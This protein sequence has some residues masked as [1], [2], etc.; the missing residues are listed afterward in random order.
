MICFTFF[1][2]T[3][4]NWLKLRQEHP[5]FQSNLTWS[6]APM[7]FSKAGLRSSRSK[8]RNQVSPLLN[9]LAGLDDLEVKQIQEEIQFGQILLSK[10]VKDADVIDMTERIK[11]LKQDKI[12]Q[13]ALL[14]DFNTKQ[15]QAVSQLVRS[16]CHLQHQ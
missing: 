15:G 2:R 10:G 8:S 9:C 13:D 16:N 14:I 7:I 12:I 11:Q 3:F 1:C 6:F 4:F 5:L